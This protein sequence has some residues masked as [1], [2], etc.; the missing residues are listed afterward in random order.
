MSINVLGQQNLPKEPGLTVD[1]HNIY[2]GVNVCHHA[3]LLVQQRVHMSASKLNNFPKILNNWSTLGPVNNRYTS[4][5]NY[6][7]PI[8]EED[9]KNC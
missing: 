7:Q 3:G 6:V 1:D 2:T 5:P 8:L 9:M 4:S